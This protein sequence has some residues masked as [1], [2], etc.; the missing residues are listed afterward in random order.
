M[1]NKYLE[2][3]TSDGTPTVRNPLNNKL[4]HSKSGAIEE[5]KEK[6]CKALKIKE[7]KNP[8]IY[9][10][11]FGLGYNTLEALKYLEDKKACFYMFEI[12][13]DL[14]RFVANDFNPKI[15]GYDI[16][17]EVVRKK[18]TTINNKQ[19]ELITGDFRKTITNIEEKAHFVFFDPFSPKTDPHL[20]TKEVFEKIYEKLHPNGKLATYSYA[21]KTRENLEAAGFILS[22]G[23]VLGRRSP[24]IIAKKTK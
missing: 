10:V 13:T 5:A 4:Y 19:Y 6:Y 7:V 17:K 16:I 9:D 8:V 22:D 1:T 14:L 3:E 21:R 11:C 15:K 23:P 24:S 20:W 12:D 18:S 2:E